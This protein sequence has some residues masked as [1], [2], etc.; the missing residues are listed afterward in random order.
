[1]ISHSLT[2]DERT[3]LIVKIFSDRDEV[4]MVE[5]LSG[6][7]AQAFVDAVSEVS[8]HSMGKLII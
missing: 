7:D 8:P 6:D 5:H 4:E 3:S 2:A 1:M